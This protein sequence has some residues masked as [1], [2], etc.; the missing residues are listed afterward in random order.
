MVKRCLAVLL[1]AA[2][3]APSAV[4]A[5]S[6]AGIVTTLEGNVTA[7]RVA[8]TTPVALKFKDE[9]F[10]QDTVTTGD[11]SLARMLLGGKAVVTVRE[12]SVLTITEVPGKSTIDLESGKFA[13]AVAREKMRP[14]EEILIRTPNAIAGVRGTVVI[15]EV[16]RQGAQLGGGV[17]AVLTNFYVLRGT[18][19]A[20]P[21]DPGTRQPLGTPLQVGTLQAYSGAGAA[22]PRVAPVPPEQVSQITSGLQPSGPKGGGDAGK[23]QVKAQAVQ[24][25][26]TLLAT[27]N[28]TPSTQTEF[29]VGPPAVDSQSSQSQG[30]DTN[31]ID[32]PVATSVEDCLQAGTCLPAFTSTGPIKFATSFANGSTSPVVFL[33]NA[34]VV[35]SGVDPFIDVLDGVDVTLGGPLAV[36]KNSIVV[37]GG[38]FLRM[39]SGSSLTSVAPDALVQL[40]GAGIGGTAALRMTNATM[41]LA[42]ALVSGT[43]LLEVNDDADGG[44]VPL[45]G[46]SHSTLTSTG[47]APLISFSDSLTLTHVGSDNAFLQLVNG[48]AITLAGPLLHGSTSTFVSGTNTK[49]FSFISVF[50]GSSITSTTPSPLV[51]FNGANVDVNG[52]LIT[53][54]R[55]PSASQPSRISLAGPLLAVSNS[56]VNTTS[57]GFLGQFGSASNCCTSIGIDQG[58]EIRSTTSLPLVSVANTTW[59]IADADSGA[60]MFAVGDTFTGAPASELVAPSLMALAGPLL[61]AVNSTITPLFNFLDVRRSTLTSTT[62]SPLVTLSNVTMTIGGTELFGNQTAG[63]FVNVIS[64]PPPFGSVNPAAF[65]TLAGPLMTASASNLTATQWIGVFGGGSLRSTTTDPLVTLTNTLFK[66]TTNT[67]PAFGARGDFAQVNGLGSTNGTTFAL[68]DLSGPLL[69]VI[70]GST[71]NMTGGFLRVL[72]GGQVQEK[73][74]SNPFVA[75][76]GGT[77]TVASD[78]SQALF[79]LIGRTGATTLE[80]VNTAELT[81]STSNLTLGTDQPLQRTGSGALLEVTNASVHASGGNGL[82]LDTALLSATAPLLNVK[83]GGSLTTAADGI[84]LSTQAKLTALGPLVRVDGGTLTIGS[85]SGVT[86]GGGSFLNVTGDLVTMNGGILNILN[87]AVLKA[88][89]GSVIR[90]GGGLINFSNSAATVNLTNNLCAPSGCTSINGVNFFFTNAGNSSNVSVTNPFKNAGSAT[91]NLS[92]GGNTAHVI[93]DGTNSKVIISGN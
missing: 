85:G 41:K 66:L 36:I 69:N 16:N 60:N 26:V 68:M 48:S 63:R 46:L 42:G 23:E 73:H 72:A 2:L 93:V 53:V 29:A 6:K 88:S 47:L 17:P 11:Q 74:P 77:H 62:T 50:D 22:T 1:S 59:T 56:T 45:F 19:T 43:G 64:S 37:T 86:V 55:S 20:Q 10:L 18:I 44:L 3:L 78:A 31:V 54:R 25:A 9:V 39:R 92:N 27:L 40:T 75:I 15:T 82:F 70:G 61:G 83:A 89:G 87:G 28:G 84:N 76:N 24:T 57:K 38:E 58:G 5:Q 7:R 91:V 90:I 33:N 30:P 32:P 12:R 8:L 4:L 79:T 81:S 14:G 13:L 35:Q 71:L 52:G 67:S 49:G 21:L 65:L 80:V 34:T 51:T